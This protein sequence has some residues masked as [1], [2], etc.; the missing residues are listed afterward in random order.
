MKKITK[1]IFFNNIGLTCNFAELIYQGGLIAIHKLYTIKF[2]LFC[3]D[4]PGKCGVN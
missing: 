3:M 1:K 2:V 4:L